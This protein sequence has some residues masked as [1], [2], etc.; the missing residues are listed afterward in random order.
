MGAY[1]FHC[2]SIEDNKAWYEQEAPRRNS[3]KEYY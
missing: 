3:Q 2:L 1:T